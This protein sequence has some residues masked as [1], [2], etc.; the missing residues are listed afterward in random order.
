MAM[1]CIDLGRMEMGVGVNVRREREDE[2]EIPSN[3]L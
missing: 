2:S 3:A 1:S